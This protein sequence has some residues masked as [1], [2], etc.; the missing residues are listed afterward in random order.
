M[1]KTK[2]TKFKSYLPT[3]TRYGLLIGATMLVNGGLLPQSFVPEFV[4]D[5]LMFELVSGAIMYVVVG[6][7][8]Y[9]SASKKALDVVFN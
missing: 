7:S 8:Y 3:L 4:S 2:M 5:P 9:T 6:I 1:P